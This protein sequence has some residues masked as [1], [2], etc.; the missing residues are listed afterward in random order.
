MDGVYNNNR[1]RG[2][3]LGGA[4]GDALGYQIEFQKNIKDK[5]VKGFFNDIGIISDDTQMTLYTANALIWRNTR[6]S[7]RGIVMPEV[8]A[9]Y[10]GY[11]DWL[12]SQNQVETTNPICWIQRL[13]EL[14][15]RR[16]PGNTCL[17]A[18][19]S[20]VKGTIENPIN[21]SKGCGG[22][23]RVA[24]IGL[25]SKSSSS[26]GLV[27]AQSCAITHGHR[28][29]IIPGWI[30]SSMIYLITYEN[31]NIIDSIKRS[32]QELESSNLFDTESI[33]IV[34]DIINKAVNLANLNKSDVDNIR[35]LGEGW[36]AEEALAI[37][38]YSCVKYQNSFKDAIICSINHDGDS[39]STGSITG[40]IM[41]AL[42][43]VESI[44]KEY[45]DKLE[46]RDV[47]TEIA[48]D[49]SSPIPQEDQD[50]INKYVYCKKEEI[51]EIPP[52]NR[53]ELE[54]IIEHFI[55]DIKPYDVFEIPNELYIKCFDSIIDIIKNHS[56][57]EDSRFVTFGRLDHLRE[58]FTKRLNDKTLMSKNPD[59]EEQWDNRLASFWDLADF[60]K[61]DRNVTIESV[62]DGLNFNKIVAE[63]DQYYN[64]EIISKREKEIILSMIQEFKLY[65]RSC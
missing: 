11:I 23:M 4:V 12:Y 24:P 65:I 62:P 47:I 34:K 41:G 5:Q 15:V 59:R 3:L 46:L 19:A 40:N 50:W 39:D 33:Q 51:K 52:L 55:Y 22:V 37:A 8:E 20:G 9:I 54:D 48:D 58:E 10:Y 53:T 56:F 64:E 6:G 61:G 57:K 28:L 29:G 49:L 32:V 35:T 36:V 44:P 25:I 63:N 18:L 1:I 21:D 26:A 13:P 43:G 45:L 31:Y 2:S 38:I 42:L 16:H 14:N 30:L 60:I 17:S 27:G 7:Y